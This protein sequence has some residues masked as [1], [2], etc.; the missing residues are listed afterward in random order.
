MLAFLCAW[1]TI[2]SVLALAWMDM[3]ALEERL[4][5]M[6]SEDAGS[7]VD[8]TFISVLLIV[9]NIAVMLFVL[10][11]L[12]S[13]TSESPSGSTGQDEGA[14]NGEREWD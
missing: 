11:P 8:P 7:L 12:H 10:R 3:N 13:S 6:G 2:L 1:S 4:Q 5:D 9:T 14:S